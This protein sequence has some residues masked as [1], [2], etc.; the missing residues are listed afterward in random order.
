MMN[1]A[2]KKAKRVEVLALVQDMEVEGF[3]FEGITKDGA[4]F[5]NGEGQYF[6]AKVIFHNEKFDA[7]D[8]LA[9]YAEAQ[10]KAAEKEK[11]KAEKQ[12]KREAKESE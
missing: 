7:E 11:A 9:E 12:A 10:A 3:E 8:R 2:E 1:Q 4:L 5:G 6:T